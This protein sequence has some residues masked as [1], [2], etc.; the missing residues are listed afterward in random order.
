MQSHAGIDKNLHNDNIHT[1]RANVS[2]KNACN[3][4]WPPGFPNKKLL[5]NSSSSIPRPHSLNPSAKSFFPEN[6]SSKIN[7]ESP[8]FDEQCSFDDNDSFCEP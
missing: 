6:L 8:S 2:C 4:F 5:F 3:D 1:S 7:Y